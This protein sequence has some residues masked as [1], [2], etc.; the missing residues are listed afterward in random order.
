M[1]RRSSID[2]LPE[3][4]R[5]ELERRLLAQAFGG[6]E[7]LADW[8]AEQGFEISKSAVHRFGQRFEERA[9]ALRMVTEQARALVEAAPDDESAVSEALIR[10]T[11]EKCFTLLL[12]AEIDP[13]NVNFPKLVQNVAHL[14]RAQ[15]YR[16]KHVAEIRRETA[17]Q[18]AEVAGREAKNAGLSADKV[19]AIRREILG[20]AA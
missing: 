14:T 1:A 11:Q 16:S 8:L 12:D 10:L 3:A 9:Q 4:V 13:A 19:D 2:L 7:A 15:V 6:Y 20:I 5:Q 17:T 18:A